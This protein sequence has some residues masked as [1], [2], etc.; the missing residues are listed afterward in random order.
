MIESKNIHSGQYKPYGDFYRVWDITTTDPK[1]KV[2]E[3][4][5]EELRKR[6][7]PPEAEWRA[8]VRYGGER[9]NDSY[10]YFAGWYRLEPTENGYKFTVCEPWAD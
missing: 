9:W 7:V 10:Y 3:Y 4:C 6:R 8:A 1:E 2:L 5:F